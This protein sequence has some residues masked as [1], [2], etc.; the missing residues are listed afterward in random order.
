[1]VKEDN[2]VVDLGDTIR[3]ADKQVKQVQEEGIS[4]AAPIGAPHIISTAPTQAEEKPSM[5]KNFVDKLAD[6]LNIELPQLHKSDK[7]T[8]G[9]AAAALAFGIAALAIGISLIH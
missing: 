6:R 3:V 4:E 5:L 8:I 7:I 2:S 9:I 1:M